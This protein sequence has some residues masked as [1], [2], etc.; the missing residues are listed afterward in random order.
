MS[1]THAARTWVVGVIGGMG[2]MATA[3]LLAKITLATPVD[4]E[5]DHLRVLVDSNPKIPDRNRAILG[6]GESPAMALAETARGLQRSGADF[7]VMA[8]NTAHAFAG[9]IRAAISIPFVSMIDEACDACVRTQP[10]AVRVGLLAAPGCLSAG[11]YQ[12]ALTRRGRQA[13]VLPDPLLAE[14]AA[15][16]YRIKTAGPSDDARIGMKTLADALVAAGADVLIAACTEVPLVLHAGDTGRPLIDATENLAQR[17]VQYA[18]G[19]ELFPA[20]Y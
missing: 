15:L 19:N 4:T 17:C 10:N 5:Q 14:F 8:C 6:N 12:R 11:I 7:L 18:R 1:E 13:V 2:P 9:A 3:D 20:T 16:L